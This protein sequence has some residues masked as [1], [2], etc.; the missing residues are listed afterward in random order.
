MK[1][2]LNIKLDLPENCQNMSQ[3]ELRQ[4]L[5]DEYVNAITVHHREKATEWAYQSILEP[6]SP[7][8]LPVSNNQA[9]KLYLHH[10]IWG[11]TTEQPEWDMTVQP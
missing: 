3:A 2:E 11:D 7:E 8:K 1:I 5:F 4:L 10:K 6:D 9:K